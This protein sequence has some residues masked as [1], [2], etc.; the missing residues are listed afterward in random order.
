MTR[1][2]AVVVVVEE[3]DGVLSVVTAI[4]SSRLDSIAVDIY[5]FLYSLCF[6]NCQLNKGEG[7]AK[8][9]WEAKAMGY[10][11]VCVMTPFPPPPRPC[12]LP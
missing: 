8:E 1:V 7:M 9:E 3:V 12:L 4:A 6:S 2:L 5:Q 11:C 10:V